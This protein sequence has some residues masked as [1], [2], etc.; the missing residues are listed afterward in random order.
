MDS[1]HLLRLA[2]AVDV[3]ARP[4][5]IV[6]RDILEHVRLP[7]QNVHFRNRQREATAVRRREPQLDDS[8]RLRIGQRS[9][10]AALIREKMAVFAP[11]PTARVTIA[12]IVKPE[13]RRNIRTPVEAS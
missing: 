13:L 9:R 1:L 3:D 12:A 2:H 10:S 7:R 8:V 11:I 5:E 4:A 6:S